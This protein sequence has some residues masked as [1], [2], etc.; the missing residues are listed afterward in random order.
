M[1]IFYLLIPVI[2]YESVIFYLVGFI[3]SLNYLSAVKTDVIS[4]G[5]TKFCPHGYAVPAA[6]KR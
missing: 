2:N 1:D 3:Y 4:I 6:G 5:I